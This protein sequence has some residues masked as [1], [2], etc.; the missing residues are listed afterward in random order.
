MSMEARR[1]HLEIEDI[2]DF[3]VVLFHHKKF[4]NEERIEITGENLFSLVDQLGRRN[5]VL[6]LHNVE[7]LSSP[8]L[9]RLVALQKKVTA[10]GGRMGIC[11][12]QPHVYAVFENANLIELLNVDSRPWIDRD[13]YGSDHQY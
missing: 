4:L 10:A 12:L 2:G 13:E 9:W 6:D 1:V 7:C 3:T 8:L 11:N 5:L